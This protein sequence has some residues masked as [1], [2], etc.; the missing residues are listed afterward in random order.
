MDMNRNAEKL[1]AIKAEQELRTRLADMPRKVEAARAALAECVTV[2]A[3]LEE[4]M[5]LTKEEKQQI[6]LMRLNPRAYGVTMS[7]LKQSYK[8]NGRELRKLRGD[9]EFAYA[10]GKRAQKLK[11]ALER[12]HKALSRALEK[13]LRVQVDLGL[14]P[15]PKR[16][17]TQ[18]PLV[19]LARYSGLLDGSW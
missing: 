6:L 14:I 4:G 13:N 3:A 10:A 12:E 17:E 2:V 1:E 19:E 7:K 8:I 5:T 18:A 11:D 9:L 16:R 15:R